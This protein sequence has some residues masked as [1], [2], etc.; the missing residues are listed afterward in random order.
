LVLYTPSILLT[1]LVD[2]AGGLEISLI[3]VEH[4]RPDVIVSGSLASGSV[5]PNGL[6]EF[7]IDCV[8]ESAFL[9]A[10]FLRI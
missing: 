6:G 2:A 7:G 9:A 3:H 8:V 10:L 1:G 5:F 4:G